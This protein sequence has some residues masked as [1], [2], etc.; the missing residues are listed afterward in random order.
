ML[1]IKSIVIT[2]CNPNSFNTIDNLRKIITE[3]RKRKFDKVKTNT[4]QL[5]KIQVNDELLNEFIKSA[6]ELTN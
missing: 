4:L 5:N 2:K 3:L 6:N 1:L